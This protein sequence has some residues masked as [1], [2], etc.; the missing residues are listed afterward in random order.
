MVNRYSVVDDSLLLSK[1]LF[2]DNIRLV[3]QEANMSTIPYHEPN[4][5][6]LFLLDGNCAESY[7]I[8]FLVRFKKSFKRYD[9]DDINFTKTHVT[10]MKK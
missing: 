9:D 4:P 1:V 10:K 8:L 3:V 5:D 7:N 2:N 6:T